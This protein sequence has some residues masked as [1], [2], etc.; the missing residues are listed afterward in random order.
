MWLGCHGLLMGE[1]YLQAMSCQFSESGRLR[2]GLVIDGQTFQEGA[3][4][5]AFETMCV[6]R[7]FP[8]N[9]YILISTQMLL[10]CISYSVLAGVPK[11]IYY[12]LLFKMTHLSIT[13]VS[14]A[15]MRCPLALLVPSSVLTF[16]LALFVKVMMRYC[17]YRGH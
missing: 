14:M 12:S 4:Y 5:S 7:L 11:E 16:H 6:C 15:M 17:E 1:G 10:S 13:S 3:R 9:I 2:S 8:S